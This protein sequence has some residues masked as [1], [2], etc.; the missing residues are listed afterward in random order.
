M[1]KVQQA[2]TRAEPLS[3]NLACSLQATRSTHPWLFSRD[4][5][6]QKLN[7]WRCTEQ[8]EKAARRTADRHGDGARVHCTYVPGARSC[9]R[10]A[11]RPGRSSWRRG[12]VA[13]RRCRSPSAPSPPTL[14]R[15]ARRA[16]PRRPTPPH[17]PCHPFLARSLPAGCSPGDDDDARQLV[18]GLRGSA[19]GCWGV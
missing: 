8:Q 9:S 7:N 13:G 6:P 10:P 4:P 11:G 18:H 16:A 2:T 1:L 3:G 5:K 19:A 15:R 12:R 17:A 14:P